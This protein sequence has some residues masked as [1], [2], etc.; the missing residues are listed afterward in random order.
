M[1]TPPPAFSLPRVDRTLLQFGQRLVPSDQRSDWVRS[2]HAELW[3]RYHRD[4]RSASRSLSSGLL[5]DALWLR[6]ES[7]RRALSGTALLC[8]ALLLTSVC[9]AAVPALMAVGGVH[10][11]RDLLLARTPRFA[12]A[13]P[14]IV[15]VSY[16]TSCTCIQH[17]TRSVRRWLKAR[18]FFAAKLVL[19][20]ILTF[21]LST[22]LSLPLQA[23]TPLIA[24]QLQMFLFVLFALLGLRWNF[25]DSDRRC[26]HCLRSLT[27]PTRVG[28]P[29]WNFLEWNGTE[30][31]C[32]DGHGLLSVPEIETSWCQSSRWL[33]LQLT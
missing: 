2:W 11:F 23:H 20:L 26:K 6:T 14:L 17:G 18:C 10:A 25:H 33:P 12:I 9:L 13:S 5:R 24:F 7:W 31:L 29:S 15:F 8:L 30:L 16:A 21:V 4:R 3:Y 22:D 28:R 32:R 19:L 27:E 1:T